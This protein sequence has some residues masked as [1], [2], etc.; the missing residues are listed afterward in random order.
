MLT[1]WAVAPD[2]FDLFLKG[3]LF[4]SAFS[5]GAF[6]VGLNFKGFIVLNA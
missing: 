5:S 2:K 6:S 1:G 3:H 4:I